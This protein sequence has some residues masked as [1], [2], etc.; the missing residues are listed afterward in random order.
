MQTRSKTKFQNKENTNNVEI[1]KVKEKEKEN[2]QLFIVD[3][4]FDEASR[5]WREN[6]KSIGNGSYKYI[7]ECVTKNGKIC[8]K[9]PAL[10]SHYCFIHKKM[11]L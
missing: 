11:N 2:I 10:G 8:N 9:R 7:C 1:E 5:H 3:I 6:K 4:D